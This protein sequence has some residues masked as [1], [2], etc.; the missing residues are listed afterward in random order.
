MA[1]VH[2]LT[3]GD[4]SPQLRGAAT[5]IY[6]QASETGI[7]ETVEAYNLKKIKDKHPRFW[8]QHKEFLITEKRGL[9]YWLWKPFLIAAKL[10]LMPENEFLIYADAGCEI[11][12]DKVLNLVHL[13]PTDP[14]ID[15]T[16]VPL[17]KFHTIAQ[18]TNKY[19]LTHMENAMQ[20]LQLPQIAASFLFIKNTSKSRAI[21]AEWFEWCVYENKSCLIDR[22]GESEGNEF[23]EHRH[24]Q[25]IFSLLLYDFQS[26]ARI[27]IR[28]I[29]IQIARDGN[30]PILAMRNKSRFSLLNGNRYR[31]KVLNKLYNTI[32]FL[33]WRE[34]K[35]F[36]YLMDDRR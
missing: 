34:E 12:A 11:V 31:R 20:Y 18:W 22:P 33:F 15:I 14:F 17:E 3:F 4:G 13:L 27:G 28:F 6:G 26:R 21:I 5:R 8:E 24:D 23:K 19:C 10:D 9:G 30:F 25:S 29:D 16:V 36:T 1:H 2:F 7:F 35:Y 32:V